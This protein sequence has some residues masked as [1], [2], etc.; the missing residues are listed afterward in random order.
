[1]V[2]KYKQVVLTIGVRIVDNPLINVL[3]VGM[4]QGVEEA[5]VNGT[6]LVNDDIE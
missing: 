6:R 1:M 4:F 2:K 3:L 5:V